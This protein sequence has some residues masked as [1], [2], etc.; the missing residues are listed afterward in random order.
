MNNCLAYF[1]KPS[2]LTV[3]RWSSGRP[4]TLRVRVIC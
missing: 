3:L 2:A 4:M 1:R